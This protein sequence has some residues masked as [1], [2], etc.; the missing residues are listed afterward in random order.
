MHMPNPKNTVDHGSQGYGEKLGD[1]EWM[2][3]AFGLEDPE[4]FEA[5]IPLEGCW[6]KGPLGICTEIVDSGDAVKVVARLAGRRILSA[7]LS[8]ERR[9][10]ETEAHVG[11]AKVDVS[12]CAD[13]DTRLV[14]V[15]G[16]LSLRTDDGSTFGSMSSSY[17]GDPRHLGWQTT[18]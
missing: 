3:V 13:L 18:A 11:V 8:R 7:T 12:A 1:Q 4:L 14:R 5:R 2:D 9:C 10:A 6:R 17:A 15:A 16:S